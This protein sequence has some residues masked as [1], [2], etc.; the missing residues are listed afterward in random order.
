MDPWVRFRFFAE[1]GTPAFRLLRMRRLFGAPSHELASGLGEAGVGSSTAATTTTGRSS[2]VNSGHGVSG[3][4]RGSGFGSGS[5]VELGAVV[6]G[7]SIDRDGLVLKT[8]C[9]VLLAPNKYPKV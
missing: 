6:G 3:S 9:P 7:L 2:G 5:G 8:R 1:H 4:G